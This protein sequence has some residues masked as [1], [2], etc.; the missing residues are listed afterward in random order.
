MNASVYTKYKFCSLYESIIP[1]Q[2]ETSLNIIG[3]C[4]IQ[5]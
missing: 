4:V 3:A 1:W 2:N 5:L